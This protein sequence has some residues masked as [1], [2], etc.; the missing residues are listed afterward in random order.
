MSYLQL[1]VAGKAG[2]SKTLGIAA[3]ISPDYALLFRSMDL[4]TCGQ[5]RYW[6]VNLVKFG[7]SAFTDFNAAC[8]YGI[9]WSVDGPYTNDNSFHKKM[10]EWWN[11]KCID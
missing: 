9:Q 4:E 6:V 1:P 5:W 3:Q 2:I 8:G 11:G 7:G 10:L